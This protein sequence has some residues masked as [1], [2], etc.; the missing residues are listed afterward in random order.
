MTAI[1]TPT[2]SD[3]TRKAEK[4]LE[5]FPD[6]FLAEIAAQPDAIL[7]AAAGLHDQLPAL[8]RVPAVRNGRQL[9]FTGMGGSYDTCYAPVTTLA[10][11]GITGVM[12]DCAELLYFRRP[13]LAG[14]T[15][16][17]VVSQSGESAEV[18]RLVEELHHGPER[19][20]IV[21][22][23]NGPDNSLARMANVALDS[24][25]GQEQGPSTMTFAGALVVLAAL[26]QVL[27]G[28]PADE[29]V[30]GVGAD[31]QAVAQSVQQ[32]LALVDDRAEPLR[33]W[34]G[35][36]QVLTLL[37]RGA[38]RAASEMGALTLKEAARFPAE[39]MQSAQFR[40][41]PLEL[42][43]REAAVVLIATEA[44]T[45]DVDSRLAAELVASGVA[46][47]HIS[48]G[49]EE[50]EGAKTIRLGAVDR[51]LAAVPAIVPIQLLAWRLAVDRGFKPG[52]YTRGSKI[53]TRE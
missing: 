46:V 44:A 43:G 8:R 30:S 27:S 14:G 33:A 24:R 53:T 9:V 49:G 7:R 36:R 12:V 11:G 13:T 35:D 28:Q 15:L 21:S 51:A 40:H 20:F 29:A 23:T 32:L 45:R 5:K 17:V 31:A 1:F 6:P 39:A 3:V 18:V 4:L 16:L 38:G 47:L 2:S 26:A 42:A 19:P 22:V 52:T 48:G 25:A 34:L 41:G 37:A 50:V 10:S